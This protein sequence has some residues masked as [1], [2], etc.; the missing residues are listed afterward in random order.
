ML[1]RWIFPCLVEDVQVL[2]GQICACAWWRGVPVYCWIVVPELGGVLCQCLVVRCTGALLSGV[3]DTT[4]SVVVIVVY[5]I[6]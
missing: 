5:L 2:G 3:W 1:G 6:V 4:D